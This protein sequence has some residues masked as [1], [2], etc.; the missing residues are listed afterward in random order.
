MGSDPYAFVEFAEH[1][2]AVNALTS[3]N[4]RVLLGKVSESNS[5]A[6]LPITVRYF[7][8]HTYLLG[9]EGQLGNIPGPSAEG[10]H[11]QYVSFLL[12]VF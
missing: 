12:P 5:T 6:L 9:D 1:N 10:G 11:Q 4:K 7:V 3:M 8:D 2:A